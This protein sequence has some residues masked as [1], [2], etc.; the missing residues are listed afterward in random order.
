M[1]LKLAAI[2]TAIKEE[3]VRRIR[4]LLIHDPNLA[5]VTDLEGKSLFHLAFEAIDSD[6]GL[7]EVISELIDLGANPT[8]QEIIVSIYL[9]MRGS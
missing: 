6:H 3:N 8:F 9:T 2:R 5:N 1:E 7:I 4:H